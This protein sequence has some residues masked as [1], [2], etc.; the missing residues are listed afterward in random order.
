MKIQMPPMEIINKRICRPLIRPASGR[1]R[2]IWA[3]ALLV[4][5]R[6]AAKPPAP[7]PA[8]VQYLRQRE[9]EIERLHPTSSFRRRR[10]C[11]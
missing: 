1:T 11:R 10:R 5:G 6:V 2:L 3:A 4:G 7:S 8:D 9:A